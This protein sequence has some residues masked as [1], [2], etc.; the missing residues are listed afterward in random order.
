[1]KLYTRTLIPRALSIR[2]IVS[3]QGIACAE[4]AR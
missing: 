4:V 3:G 2:I 1:M